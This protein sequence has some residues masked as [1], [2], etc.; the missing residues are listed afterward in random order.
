MLT[1]RSKFA[2]LKIHEGGLT[3]KPD[4]LGLLIGD[5]GTDVFLLASVRRT[6]KT[7]KTSSNSGKKAGIKSTGYWRNTERNSLFPCPGRDEYSQAHA[8]E[9][10]D[11]AVH[12]KHSV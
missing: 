3:S 7:H 1:F 5:V 4:A 8:L 2:I 11:D 12:A 6:R 10:P 9:M